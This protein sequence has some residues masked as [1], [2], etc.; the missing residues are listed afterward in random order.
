[1]EKRKLIPGMQTP[2]AVFIN[3]KKILMQKGEFKK[4]YRSIEDKK[5]KIFKGYVLL[6][7]LYKKAG[8]TN[9]LFQQIVG[10]EIEKMGHTAVVRIDSLPLKYKKVA[11]ECIN[12]GEYYTYT[13]LN[14]GLGLG[15]DKLHYWDRSKE[16]SFEHKRVGNHKLFKLSKAFI[17]FVSK[18]F[19]PFLLDNSNKKYADYTVEMQGLKIGFY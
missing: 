6:Q 11:H 3:P 12:L 2:N 9:S 7:E 19:I 5:M 15:V 1:M 8:V 18:G 17:G 10:V 14:D 16:M 4:I 13:A